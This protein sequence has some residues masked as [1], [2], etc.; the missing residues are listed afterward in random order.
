MVEFSF[1]NKKSRHDKPHSGKTVYHKKIVPPGSKTVIEVPCVVQWSL[2]WFSAPTKLNRILGSD[3]KIK[4]KVSRSRQQCCHG[5]YCEAIE[6]RAHTEAVYVD[7][8]GQ[9]PTPYTQEVESEQGDERMEVR[10]NFTPPSDGDDEEESRDEKPRPLYTQEQCTRCPCRLHAHP[11]KRLSS[12]Q[13]TTA[14]LKRAMTEKSDR[15]KSRR[16]VWHHENQVAATRGARDK[17]P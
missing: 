4:K 9:S 12:V 3:L 11:T 13:K 8:G 10:G 14:A 16:V 1:L 6:W 17:A 7:F 2:L 5:R 15:W